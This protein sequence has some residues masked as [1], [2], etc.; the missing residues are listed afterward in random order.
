MFKITQDNFGHFGSL[1]IKNSK[2]GILL[3]II[4]DFGA[5]INKLIINNSPFS[6]IQGY[7]SAEELTKTHPFFSRSAKLFPFP[8]RLENGQYQFQQQTFALP[9]NFP[10]SQ[11]AVH[12]L[13]YNQPFSILHTDANVDYAEVTLRYNTEH[14]CAGFPHSFLLDVIYRID[15]DGVL[16]CTTEITNTGVNSLPYGDAWH[17]YFSLGCERDQ[18]KLTM[19]SSQELVS[20]S[21][22]PTGSF[23]PFDQFTKGAWLGDAELNHCFQFEL[24]R[25]IALSLERADQ[26]ASIRY[27]QDASYPFIQLYTPN[28][29]STLAIEP[30]TCPANA[31]NNHI[32]LKELCPNQLERFTW[33]CQVSYQA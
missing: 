20:E 2:R 24:S 8:N 33:Q 30:M 17:P 27:Q 16:T 5:I 14:L 12:G 32:G 22:L 3:E 15:S 4:Q 25:P 6:F 7:Q 11:D 21:G 13:L 19:P 9:A 1:Q 10:W 18:V 31:F 29:E 26:R 28:S 23:K